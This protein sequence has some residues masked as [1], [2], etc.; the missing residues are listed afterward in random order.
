MDSFNGFLRRHNLTRHAET[1]LTNGGFRIKRASNVI[2]RNLKFHKPPE[3]KDLVA[4]D[5]ATKV[6]VDHCDFSTDGLV[7]DK[8]HYDGLLDITHASDSVTVSWTKF[9]DH[10]K[11]SLVGHSDNNGNEDRGR[12]RV[13]YHHNH[14]KNVN[15]RLPSLRFGTGHIYSSC[16][17]DNPASGINSRMGAQV[18]VEQCYFSN[19][20]RAIVTN[21]DS[22]APGAAVQR[23]NVFV[24]SDIGIT[25]TGS[26]SP[27]YSYT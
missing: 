10:W 16:Y 24:N 14:W 15:S 12:L 20:R 11:G 13:T 27:P 9:H 4:L 25:Q 23:N 22:D 21:L 26:L 17:E 19:T 5:Q 18:L 6:W 1:G 7:G 2:L 8:D 3:G